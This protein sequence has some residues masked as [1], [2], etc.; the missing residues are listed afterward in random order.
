LLSLSLMGAQ[1]HPRA[2]ESPNTF[3]PLRREGEEHIQTVL[4]T[5]PIGTF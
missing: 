3:S 2:E 4:F 1:E 5:D